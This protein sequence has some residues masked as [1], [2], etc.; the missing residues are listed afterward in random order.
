MA[1]YFVLVGVPAILTV[2]LSSLKY[3]R[4]KIDECVINSFFIIWL[5]LLVLRS[6][7]VG[8]DL[9][10]YKYHFFNYS[11]LGWTEIIK[12][13]FTGRYEAGYLVICK[14]LSYISKNFHIVKALC[15]MVS[16]IPIWKLYRNEGRYGF[17]TIVTFINVSPFVMY[18]SGLRQAMAMAFVVPCYYFCKNNELKKF[19][20]T[21]F[22]AFLFHKSALI[23]LCMY[24]VYH[25]Q[26]KKTV[27]LLYLLPLEL[28]VYVY[29]VPIFRLLLTFMEGK[30]YDRYVGSIGATGAYAV[31]L[32]LTVILIYTYFIPDKE[33]LD[34]DTIGLR[35]VFTMSVFLQVFSAASTVAMRMNYYFLLLVPLLISKII[36]CGNKNYRDLIK[37][38]I[39]CMVVFFTVYY[40]YGAY[41]D[42][43]ILQVYP[44][45]TFI[46]D[47]F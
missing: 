7:T 5:L 35:N 40:F 25:L 29:N 1:A 28:F 43:D 15:A 45:V 12:G 17:L 24:P 30:Y 36:R 4:E 16:I 9:P 14:V 38:S 37:L 42:T 34:K 44:Y 3:K 47:T 26:L 6:E 2:L 39:I 41:T 10:V 8:V 19:V 23:M 20:L 18:F 27:H 22:V 46:K 13:I 11:R 21:V 33:L 32:L 31:T